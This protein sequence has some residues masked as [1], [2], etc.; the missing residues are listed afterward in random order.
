MDESIYPIQQRHIP[1]ARKQS[2]HIVCSRD[3]ERWPCDVATVLHF[4]ADRAAAG[5]QLPQITGLLAEVAQQ[6]TWQAHQYGSPDYP[7]G[8]GMHY[9]H[10]A[11]DA[12]RRVTQL[13]LEG[14][15]TWADVLKQ[16]H[17]EVLQQDEPAKLREQLIWLAAFV[18]GWADEID[19][20]PPAT[21]A[22]PQRKGHR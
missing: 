10:Q 16:I 11:S 14:K 1:A 21:S 9:Q 3:G 2:G 6:R 4:F 18:V 13:L 15:L 17:A 20:R 12:Y 5:A 8:T 7:D 19:K 22:P